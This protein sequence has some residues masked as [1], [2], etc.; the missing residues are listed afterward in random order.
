MYINFE[1]EHIGF[2]EESEGKRCTM[3]TNV[4][5]RDSLTTHYN[6]DHCSTAAKRPFEAS[7]LT[8]NPYKISCFIT[9]R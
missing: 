5:H 2:E 7:L 3:K 4:L 8:D 1:Y 6:N 9:D